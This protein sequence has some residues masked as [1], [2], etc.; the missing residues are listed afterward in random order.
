MGNDPAPLGFQYETLDFS[1]SI[2]HSN[3]K[4]GIVNLS[5]FLNRLVGNGNTRKR[6]ARISRA[7]N[8][9]ILETKQL[10]YASALFLPAT[11]ELNIVL[12]S[13][14]TVRVSAPNG[15]VLIETL[16]GTT[17]TPI[18]SVSG[19]AASSVQSIVIL[20]GDDGNTIDLSGVLAA[21]FTSLTSILVDGANGNDLLIGSPDFADSII[22][23]HGHDTIQGN[24]GNDTLLGGDGDDSISGGTGDDS[25]NSGDGDDSVSGDDGNDSIN[26]S[27]G[28]DTVSGGN[29]NDT[30]GG[31]NGQD[32]LNGDAG[33]DFINGDGGTDTINGGDGN[34]S[35]LGGEFDDSL[36]GGN[37]NDTINGQAGADNINGEAGDDSLLGGAGNDVITSGDG[38]DFVNAG[39]GN[40]T[41]T[42]NAG[43]D[44][45]LGGA[46]Q[47]SING[48]QGNDTVRGQAGDDTLFGGGGA[49]LVDGGEG[50]DLVQ[51][52]DPSN[53]PPV[54]I[55]IAD[56]TSTAESD[57]AP[58][59]FGPVINLN[60]GLPVSTA[61]DVDLGDVDGDGDL[62]I[63]TLLTQAV[64]VS[65]NQGNAVFG[66]PVR[67]PVG[68]L[69][70]GEI[71]L[72]DIDNDGD[73]DVTMTPGLSANGNSTGSVML[74]N[75]SG[76]FGAEV[77][78]GNGGAFGHDV[79]DVN[80]D[81]NLDLIYSGINLTDINVFLGNGDGTFSAG[82]QLQV[83]FGTLEDVILGDWDRDG[84]LDAA[85]ADAGLGARIRILTNPGN[86]NLV[87][88]SSVTVPGTNV[89]PFYLVRGDW[90]QDGDLDIAVNTGLDGTVVVLDNNGSGGFTASQTLSTTGILD[91][92]AF[93]AGDFDG[94]GDLDIA[95]FPDN[96]IVGGVEQD[97]IVFV[98]NNGVFGNAVQ[99]SSTPFTSSLGFS[100][101]CRSGDLNGDGRVD[102]VAANLFNGAILLNAPASP[103]VLTF[104]VSL[105][106][107]STVP[108]TVNYQTVDGIAIGGVDY[109][110]TSGVLTFAPGEV[111]K[112][113]PVQ[114]IGDALA[115]P[116]ETFFLNLSNATGASISDRQAQGLIVD[117]DGGIPL[118]TL[119]INDVA[120]AAEGNGA[121]SLTFTVSLS[122]PASGTVTVQFETGD[123][124]ALAGLDYTAS[125]GVLT[126]NPGVTA[127]TLTVPVLGDNFLEGDEIFFVNLLS[128]TGATL[129][130]SQGVGTIG[131]DD[132]FIEPINDTLLGGNG[133]DTLV[134]SIGD[135]VLNGQA[136]NDS[137]LGGDGNDSLLGGSGNDTLDGQ[138]GNDTLDGQGGD[139]VLIG[140][141]GDDTFVL[142]N[143]AGGQDT[144]DGGDGFN[145]LVV[146]G[147][148]IA[149]TIT[150]DA[151]NGFIRVVRGGATITA[152]A[153]TQSVTV[154]GLGGND[155]ITIG[156]LSGVPATLLTVNGGEGDD[157]ISA[158]GADIGRVRLFLSGD[159]G[160]DSIIGSLGK[161]TILGG[162][163]SDSINGGAGDDSILGLAGNDVLAGGTGNDTVNGGDGADFVT[164]QA[165]DDSLDGGTGN[166]T[167]RGFEGNDTLQGQAG[168]DLLNG[169]DGDDSILGG[170][171]KDQIT[172]GAGD[173]TLDGGRNDD[174][175]NGN[176]GNDKI[177]GDHG[178]DYINAGTDTDTVNGGDGND[179]IFAT[180]GN[181]LLNGGDGNDNINAGGGN[182]TVVGGDGNDSILGGGGNDVILGG[183]GDD[184]IDGQGGTD[185]IAG[186]QGIDVIVDPPN[187]IDEQ[188][189]LS[190]AIISML[191]AV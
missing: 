115:E 102:L 79:G 9:E 137:I 149:D 100:E 6:A 95:T 157:T 117:D 144:I 171:G 90:N 93:T 143:G 33:D 127:L 36:L 53:T 148:G 138:A 105:T 48:N 49:D 80:G 111:T 40:D 61:Q 92:S 94:D 114:A 69:L 57:S 18:T 83:S 26:A 2:T 189:V 25:I 17:F 39:M 172:G 175:I 159:N 118:P 20:G 54:Q 156:S 19:V 81:G 23:G 132:S 75:G 67:Y 58:F 72:A 74:N 116:D 64:A 103:P 165:G 161:D 66:L 45:L 46:G 16:N 124:T 77:Q 136:G 52:G 145:G 180:D 97:I 1:D 63:V 164:G 55:T 168:D 177:R 170:V 31:A 160:N 51:S 47:D 13:S 3:A 169:M 42:G 22:G 186:N 89:I 176:S 78:I 37:G 108:V 158:S 150:I 119:S 142:G 166:D 109:V 130:D 96:V 65:F 76:V 155:L 147:T 7:A 163:G 15:V 128:P 98:N 59:L 122:V 82:T 179:T 43:D 151:P 173:D 29:G 125:T 110:S 21:Q 85:V 44:S 68:S 4:E 154:N 183:D 129:A 188:Y 10:L 113:V 8:I 24:G 178:N 70:D 62:D 41:V 126:F 104:T 60:Y 187:E 71:L 112:T 30:I 152:S 191:D 34:D 184:Y 88:Q 5:Q 134:G 167:L 87:V 28:Q 182:D 121:A 99:F 11:G 84:D 35:I 107:P 139:D 133:D 131:N 185:T 27:N 73:L 123:R 86:G 162:N 120:L 91:Y 38:N 56:V 32:S 14:D 181:D 106:Q 190:A 146:N 153:N 50:N 101:G 12:N 140:G 141:G 174:T 135:D